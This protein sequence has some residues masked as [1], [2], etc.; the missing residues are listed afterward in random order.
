M[1]HQKKA[2][3]FTRPV[4]TTVSLHFAIRAPVSDMDVTAE[5]RSA[6]TARTFHPITN[7]TNA[8]LV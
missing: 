2:F 5:S 1:P 3:S 6:R 8:L 4:E 7:A